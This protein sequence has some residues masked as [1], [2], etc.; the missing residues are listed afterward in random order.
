MTKEQKL[1][2]EVKSFSIYSLLIW[3]L[4]I[5]F[6]F[7]E[8]FLRVLP[9]TLASNIINS[10]DFS[11]EQFAMLGSAYYI[12]Y[13]LMQIP[14]GLLL[15][16]VPVKL[17][18]VS[19]CFLCATGILWFSFAAGFYGAFFSR[20][21][22]GFG[23]AFGFVG[24]MVVTM[25]WFPKKY[26]AFM[27]GCGQFLGAIGPMLAGAPIALL[28]KSFNHQW[29]PIFLYVAIFG[30]GLTFL[31]FLFFKSKPKVQKK[32]IVFVDKEASLFARIAVLLKTRQV[33]MVMLFSSTVYVTL[34]LLGAFWGTTYLELKGLVK[35]EAAFVISMIWVGLAAG[36][37]IF[38]K[39]SD[40][41]KRRKPMLMI[42]ALFGL[43][44]SLIV[45]LFPVEN[46]WVLCS[47]FF[48]IGVGGAGQNLSFAIISEQAPVS[49]KGTALGLN[50]TAIMS[51]AATLPPAITLIANMF[52]P[53]EQLT[54]MALEKSLLVI[55]IC[56]LAAF[57]TGAFLVEETFC[58]QKNM[59]HHI[60]KT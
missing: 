5:T 32:T 22:I 59:I 48:L 44:S 9:A 27:I 6:F 7:Y 11:F 52:A 13:S 54:Y 38:G 12:T 26:F 23:S 34:P 45:L 42:S 17:L 18:V 36:C 3:S 8:F 29:R 57:L 28:L 15:D 51:L 16:K 10:M 50:N 33:W 55:P 46:M 1:L 41:M 47:L 25:N 58:R 30:F 20:L 56:F 31:L 4:A 39:L 35:S 49:L 14:V 21:L 37:P 53:G 60:S 40:Q 2:S 19:A 24:Y 43:G